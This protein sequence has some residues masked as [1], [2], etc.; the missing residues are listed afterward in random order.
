MFFS[1]QKNRLEAVR[2][3]GGIGSYPAI[4]ELSAYLKSASRR[5]ARRIVGEAA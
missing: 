4:R 2:L 3:V 1:F 5:I